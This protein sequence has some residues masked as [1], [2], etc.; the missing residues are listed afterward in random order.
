MQTAIDGAEVALELRKFQNV[1]GD[2]WENRNELDDN[3]LVTLSLALESVGRRQDALDVLVSRTGGGSDVLATLAG[4][5][6]RRWLSG[7]II[8]DWRKSRELY[9]VALDMATRN[10]D[11]AQAYYHAI[12][13]AFLDLM[14][15]HESSE[16]GD[17]IRSMA[18]SAI[19]FCSRSP[20]S[21]WKSATLG[22][23]YL[24][25]VI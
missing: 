7:R 11:L 2:L 1:V 18:E 25:L 17:N 22:E 13:I 15:L 9:L 24:I 10:E 21:M 8:A 4:R 5:L 3:A 23:A 20:D 6:K 12:N 14:A 16:I 19:T